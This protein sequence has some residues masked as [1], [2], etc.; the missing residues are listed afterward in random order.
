MMDAFFMDIATFIW[1]IR[2]VKIV[3]WTQYETAGRANYRPWKI[4]VLAM[5]PIW[6]LSIGSCTYL[7]A[8][9]FHYCIAQQPFWRWS[10]DYAYND[11]REMLPLYEGAPAQYCV[12]LEA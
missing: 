11:D 9:F 2:N 6:I 1:N 5:A 10:F 12:R 8:I 4:T 3:K 7:Y